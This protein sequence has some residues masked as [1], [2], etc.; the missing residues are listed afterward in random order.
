M[1]IV[2]SEKFAC[3]LVTKTRKKTALYGCLEC[4]SKKEERRR[5]VQWLMKIFPHF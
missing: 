1:K 3:N 2:S 5:E 4:N